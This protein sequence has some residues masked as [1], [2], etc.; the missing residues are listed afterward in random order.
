VRCD[1]AGAS[2]DLLDWLTEQGKIRGRSLDYS[3]GFPL[4]EKVRDAIKLV[5]KAVRTPAMDA[6]GG[7]PR[8]R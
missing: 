6:G 3:V 7:V 4:T 2:H 5:P 8:W 1:G